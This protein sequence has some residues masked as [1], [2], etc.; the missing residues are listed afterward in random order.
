MSNCI[1]CVLVWGGVDP[2]D[3]DCVLGSLIVFGSKLLSDSVW[4]DVLHEASSKIRDRCDW[5]VAWSAI[6]NINGVSSSD[7]AEFRVSSLD[8][9]DGGLQF[10]DE[11]N[12][13][14]EASKS[15]NVEEIFK[16]F[17]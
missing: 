15:V 8:G 12:P 2:K 11:A 13:W 10:I 5:E 3:K 9:G 6:V 7:D 17:L 16:I 4:V 1:Q 14:K